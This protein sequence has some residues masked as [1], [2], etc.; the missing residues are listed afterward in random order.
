MEVMMSTRKSGGRKWRKLARSVGDTTMGACA[1]SIKEGLWDFVY[2]D[3]MRR[4]LTWS[5]ATEPH[6]S[7]EL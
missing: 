3:G 1:G 2:L 4:S 6:D 7:F 5:K